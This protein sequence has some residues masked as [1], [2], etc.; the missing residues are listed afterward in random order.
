MLSRRKLIALSGA[1]WTTA[2]LGTALASRASAAT[3]S[4]S[5]STSTTVAG[6]TLVPVP[7]NPSFVFAADTSNNA[8]AGEASAIASAYWL[9]AYQ[10]TNAQ[11]QTYLD[12]TGL[13]APNYWD[14]DSY[15]SDRAAHP[16]LYISADQVDAYCTWLTAQSDG[17]TFRLPTEAEWENAA[18]GPDSLAYP[19]GNDTGT[20]YANGVLTS[21]YNFN[22]VCAAYYLADYGD[23]IATYTDR[24]STLYGQSFAISEILSVSSTGALTGWL[25]FA[26]H[27]GFCFTDV[28]Q[29]CV[30][31][32]GHTTPVGAYPTG[33]SAYGAYDMAGNAFE[34]TSSL[35]TAT[36]GGEAG[37]LCNCVRGGSWYASARSGG[38]GYRGEGRDG[39]GG[40]PTIGFRIAADQG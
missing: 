3:T 38:T 40:Y 5:T 39:S 2:A 35:V 14:G 27:T 26:T 10:V 32:G 12:D 37:T 11:W 23:T 15:P 9:G 19:W 36:I 18:R 21:N 1:A 13:S 20:A 17:W 31:A 33:V 22:A 4:T 34:W 8:G 30:D 16:V 25:T 6:Q 24:Q 7:A 28:Y 29:A